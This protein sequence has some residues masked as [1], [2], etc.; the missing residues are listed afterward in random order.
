VE[1]CPSYRELQ[2]LISGSHSLDDWQFLERH[3]EFCGRCRRH[4]EALAGVQN[5]VPDKPMPARR[6]LPESPALKRAMEQFLANSDPDAAAERAGL[7]LA[8]GQGVPLPFLQP[9]DRPGFLGKL[10]PYE[11]RRLVGRGGTGIVFEGL[12]PMLNRTVAVKVLSP[13]LAVSDQA[14]CRFLREARA[15]A[16]LTH[17]HI[18]TIHAVDQANGVPF[19]VLE[20]VS[21]ETLAGRLCRDGRLSLSDA[22]RLGAQVARGL[23]AAHAKGLVHRDIKP[24]NLLL[25][26][27]TNRV[28]IADFGLVKVTCEDSI[29]LE[30]T[31]AGTPEFMSPEQASGVGVGTQSDLFSLGAVLYTACSGIS[32][33]RAESPLR[34]LE[35]VCRESP[36]PL[37]QVDPTLPDW[38]C[39]VVHR[40]LEKDPRARIA[41]AAEL[42][43]ALER[44]EAIQ[45][46]PISESDR[47][48]RK[49]GAP[50]GLA[51]RRSRRLTVAALVVAAAAL[52][53]VAGTY[54]GRANEVERESGRAPEVGFKIA[55][56]A[57]TFRQL[58]EALQAAGDGD[59]IE[60]YGDGPFPT[61][62]LRTEGKRLT[63][64]AAGS[65]K[66]LF[67][68]ESPGNR[69]TQPFISADADLRLEG[70]ELHWSFDPCPG[71]SEFE[72]L[73]RCTLSSTRGRLTLSHCRITAGR[74]NGCVGGSGQ[75][76]VMDN[77]RLK[78]STG[79]CVFWRASTEGRLS[80][81]G[82]V[83]DG[84]IA[85][86]V[87][88]VALTA[89][90]KP[91]DLSLAQNTV[92]AEKTLQL[93]VDSRPRQPLTVTA[94]HNTF[95][96]LHMLHLRPPRFLRRL[97][98]DPTELGQFVRSFVSWFEEGNSYRRGMDFVVATEGPRPPTPM[99]A[100]IQSL[101][102]WLR[103]WG[104]PETQ[105]VEGVIK[106]P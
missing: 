75:Q 19:L 29:T 62:P 22:V 69:N 15:A 27:S 50:A 81:E 83:L 14:R 33:F 56:R 45:A 26:A 67:L 42:A 79:V 24:E 84:Q 23:A 98:R 88:A 17:E 87:F 41:S 35:R 46:I 72:L 59:V 44:T 73:S 55:G 38:F 1:N 103:L 7:D 39:T 54:L 18:V 53:G 85:L 82:C 102:Q 6:R 60:V 32:P 63:V 4:F 48:T 74:R 94:R 20:Y 16:A 101:G 68:P 47:P 97:D 13:L 70:L 78:A 10:G 100:G 92:T 21:G 89:R 30:G 64:R 28:K 105:S 34:S 43:E 57:E 25:E 37:G 95:D 11:V 99:S 3:L 49:A 77:C 40:L 31:I 90:P 8:A 91:A 12:D 51:Q 65:S 2:R 96:S 36:A 93:R 71:E 104:L 106:L 86:S 61:P 58:Y 52:A 76:L 66:P 9:T 80:V 5:V